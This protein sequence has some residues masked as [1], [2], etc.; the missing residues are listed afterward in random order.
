MYMLSI[1]LLLLSHPL[2][3]S[4]ALL[5]LKTL[6]KHPSGSEVLSAPANLSV[7]LS[8]STSLEDPDASSEALRCIA[9]TLVLVERARATW[10][11]KEVEGG[12][13]CMALLEVRQSFAIKLSSHPFAIR[14]R[15]LLVTYSWHLESCFF[16]PPR[17]PPLALSYAQSWRGNVMEELS[18]KS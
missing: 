18:W 6:G 8:L 16:V 15:R 9:N 5:A 13:A 11:S 17:S 12:V 3:A 10:V 1:A 4:R 2:D 14:N 7:L